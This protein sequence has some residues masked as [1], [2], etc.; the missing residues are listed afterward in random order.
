MAAT[1]IPIGMDELPR[2][3]DLANRIWPEA[4]AGILPAERIP[5]MLAEIYDLETL[6][7]DISARHHQY[8]LATDGTSDLGYA[9]ALGILM[10]LI[11]LACSSIYLFVSR[12]NS[13]PA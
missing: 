7:S 5:G 3:A 11:I 6:R 9:S 12:P 8:W 10:L 2:V 1:I 13:Q 4:F